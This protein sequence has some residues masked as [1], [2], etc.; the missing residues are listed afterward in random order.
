MQE[1]LTPVQNREFV[2]AFIPGEQLEA[3]KTTINSALERFA[4][5]KMITD[6]GL[7][8]TGESVSPA[9]YAFRLAEV[10]SRVARHIEHADGNYGEAAAVRLLSAAPH[11]ARIQTELQR[12]RN[13]LR[14]EEVSRHVHF[15]C[16][17]NSDMIAYGL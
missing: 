17:V 16:T 3:P 1:I 4:S 6:V 11:Y 7:E 14:K 12:G 8:R 5:V 13:T 9:E 15:G 2:P 10:G